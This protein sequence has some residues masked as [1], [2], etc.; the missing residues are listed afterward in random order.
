MGFKTNNAFVVMNKYEDRVQVRYDGNLV[1]M[2]GM[3]RLLDKVEPKFVDNTWIN[4]IKAKL[5]G[6]HIEKVTLTDMTTEVYDSLVYGDNI[7]LLHVGTGIAYNLVKGYRDEMS[8]TSREATVDG[9]IYPLYM[10]KM[11]GGLPV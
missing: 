1:I 5:Y 6:N 2:S 7:W 10:F 9:T 8:F 3:L 4:R 11:I